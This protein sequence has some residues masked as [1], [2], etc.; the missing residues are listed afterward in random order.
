M[1]R[2]VLSDQ[3]RADYAFFVRGGNRQ[4]LKKI[5]ALIAELREHPFS[6][7]GKPESLKYTLTGYWSR[8][9]NAEH[10]LIY[11]VNGDTVEVYVLTMRYHYSK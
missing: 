3:A 5:A 10:R 11:R 7:T 6:G 4:I 2:V 8:R 9:I 1:Y